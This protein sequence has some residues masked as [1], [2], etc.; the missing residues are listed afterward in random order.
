MLCQT[1]TSHWI[2]WRHLMLPNRFAWSIPLLPGAA[3]LKAAFPIASTGPYFLRD[4]YKYASRGSCACYY[5]GSPFPQRESHHPPTLVVHVCFHRKKRLWYFAFLLYWSLV[6]K[7]KELTLFMPIRLF[8]HCRCEWKWGL[9][10]SSSL[11]ICHLTC[12]KN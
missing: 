10:F 11:L 5:A 8:S 4:K 9:W 3:D 6:S 2:I 1:V 7:D 12:R